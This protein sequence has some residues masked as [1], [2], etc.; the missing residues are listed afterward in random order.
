MGNK[1]ASSNFYF[2]DEINPLLFQL[3][4]NAE[5]A[6]V[7]DPN[8]SLIKV[9]QLGEAITKFIVEFYDLQKPERANQL[10]MINLIDREIGLDRNIK[11]LLHVIRQLGNSANHEFSTDHRDAMTGLKAA[12]TISIW[13]YEAF[14]RSDS[15]IVS[16]A[17]VAPK[18]PSEKYNLLLQE[19]ENLERKLAASRD[20]VNVEERLAVATA[21]LEKEYSIL[22]QDMDAK[23]KEAEEMVNLFEDEVKALEGYENRFNA[24][25]TSIA[26]SNYS[27]IAKKIGQLDDELLTE[28]MTRVIIDSQ[29][30]CAGWEADTEVLR[31]S[32]GVRPEAHR[33]IAIAEWPTQDGYADYVLFSGLTPIATVEAKKKNENVAGKIEQAERYAQDFEMTNDFVPAWTLDGRNEPWEYDNDKY[34]IPFVY[35]SNGRPYFKQNLEKS[36]TWFRDVRASS[37]IR[38]ALQS[39]H[40]PQGLLDLLKRDQEKAHERLQEEG[41]EYLGLRYYQESAINAIEH[42]IEHNQKNIL[43]AMATGTGKTRTILGLAYRLLKSERFK[44]ILFLV[45]RSALGKQTQDVMKDYI[46]EQNQGFSAIYSTADLQVRLPDSNVRVQVATVQAMVNRLFINPDIDIP[47]DEYDC[48]IVDEAHRGYTLDQEMTEEQYLYRDEKQ[49]QSTYRRVLDYFDATK[50]AL[51]ATPAKHTVDIFGRPVF[52]YSYREAVIDGYLIDHEPPKRYLTLLNQKGITFDKGEEVLSVDRFTGEASIT[53]LEDELNFEV[54]SFNRRV[55]ADDFTRVICE[56]LAKNDLDPFGEEKTLIFCVTDEHADTTKRFL[57]EYFLDLYAESYNEKAVMKITGKSDKVDDLIKQFKNEKYPNIAITVDLLSTGIDVPEICNIVFLRKVKSRILYEQMIGRATRKCDEIG[58][59]SFK[60][61]D[62]VD[63]Y[64]TLQEVSTMK[65][66]VKDP[67]ISAADLAEELIELCKDADIE[68]ADAT[69]EKHIEDV[70]AQF[71]QKVMRILKKADQKAEK[72]PALREKLDELKEM[73]GIEPTKLDQHF[74]AIGAQKTSEFLIAHPSFLAELEKV[75]RT[76]GD[77]NNPI[78]S[79]HK[80]SITAIEYSYGD[81]DRPEDYLESFKDFILTNSNLNTALSIVINRPSDLTRTDLKEIKEILDANGFTEQYLQRAWRANSNEDIAASIIG[82]IRQAALG[83]AMTPFE[84]RVEKAMRKVYKLHPWS[85][86]QTTWLDRIEKQL[87]KEIV[88]DRDRI[89]EIFDRDGGSKRLDK[90]L[91]NQLDL[92]LD[93]IKLNL[94]VA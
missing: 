53:E 73:W 68:K 79:E 57:D 65:P 46:I 59:V 4:K 39:F 43:V 82:F 12:H 2:L 37:N 32:K 83:G 36:G 15:K 71:N 20:D 27:T 87:L 21:A 40:S 64:E 51:T 31:Y 10:D 93:N 33:N 3:A 23:V 1:E 55:I 34:L 69:K 16:K 92:V 80:D 85:R 58:K 13:F 72:R 25:K 54:E 8:T 14:K 48:I 90:H 75:R 38:R 6:F 70:L 56:D 11:N 60:I 86:V 18:D 91:D 63:L 61:Y 76:I 67:N 78:I 74:H 66:I 30:R 62:P 41:M 94:W 49:Y 28:E 19:K 24:L 89:S 26:K 42:A 35:S 52:T 29:L 77:E 9:R 47:I 81:Y 45:D 84:E 17:F 88:L 44:R 22:K 7:R 5:L 50:I